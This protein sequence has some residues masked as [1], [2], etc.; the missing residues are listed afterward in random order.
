MSMEQRHGKCLKR[1]ANCRD[2]F[3]P[4][5]FLPSPFGFCRV[6]ECCFVHVECVEIFVFVES[7][8]ANFAG[9]VVRPEKGV[10]TK[11]SFSLEESLNL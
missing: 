10:I 7:L 4:V 11:G 1:C 3:F 5:P 8:A 2:V 9:I 6:K